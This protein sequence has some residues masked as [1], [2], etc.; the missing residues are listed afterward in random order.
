[1]RNLFIARQ[2]SFGIGPAAAILIAAS[3]L[4]PASAL[5]QTRAETLVVVAEE[6]PATLDIDAATANVPTHEVSWN[7]YDRLITL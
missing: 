1:M 5:A 6:G 3:A 7:V 4:A 2:L